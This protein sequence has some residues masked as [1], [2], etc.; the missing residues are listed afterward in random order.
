MNL[1]THEESSEAIQNN[2]ATPLQIFIH[3]NE[4]AGIEDCEIFREQLS[5]TIDYYF[6]K[7]W[8]GNATTAELL[9]EL[10][11]RARTGGYADYKTVE[12]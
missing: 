12:N 8:L 3:A 7:A 2:S 11:S 4:P 9:E 10:S 5:N 6:N 1:P